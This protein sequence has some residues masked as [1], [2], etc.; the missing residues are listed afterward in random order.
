MNGYRWFP[1]RLAGCIFLPC[2]AFIIAG[3]A[4]VYP[5]LTEDRPDCDLGAGPCFRE[6]KGLRITFDIQPKPVKAMGDLTFSVKVTGGKVRGGIGIDLEMPG[7][8]MGKN[9]IVLKEAG[10]GTFRG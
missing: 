10:E 4:S 8:F 3:A 6:M 1:S 5:A 9:R 2:A 7:M